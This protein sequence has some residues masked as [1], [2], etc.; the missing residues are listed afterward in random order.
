MTQ[1][2]YKTFII[3]DYFLPDGT[4]VPLLI[5][6]HK[7]KVPIDDIYTIMLLE[8]Y[9]NE[10]W[11]YENEPDFNDIQDVIINYKSK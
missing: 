8:R 11:C 9:Q 4:N 6:K 10:N 2:Y 1:T 5:K 3:G 7:V